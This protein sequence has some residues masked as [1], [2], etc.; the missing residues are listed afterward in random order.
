MTFPQ[1]A[2]VIGAGIMGTGIAQTCALAGISVALIDVDKRA[3]PSRWRAWRALSRNWSRK[4][5]SPLRNARQRSAEP[6]PEQTAML[7]RIRD[8]LG[9]SDRRLPR[10]AS[11]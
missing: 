5:G 9:A 10:A 1:T 8:V 3:L 4:T 6:S 2:A 11:R 7:A